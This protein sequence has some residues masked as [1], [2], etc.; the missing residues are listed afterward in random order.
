M[1]GDGE[2]GSICKSWRVCVKQSKLG[3]EAELGQGLVRVN[4][5][6]SRKM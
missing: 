1:A 2:P 3:K 5:K 6:T 4:G